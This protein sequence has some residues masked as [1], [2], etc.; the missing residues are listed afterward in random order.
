MTAYYF[1]AEDAQ[2]GFWRCCRLRPTAVIV[3]DTGI[4]YYACPSCA[5]SAKRAGWEVRPSLLKANRGGDRH[6]EVALLHA[7]YRAQQRY[8]QAPTLGEQLLAWYDVRVAWAWAEPFVPADAHVAQWQVRPPDGYL[9]QEIR[10]YGYT[11]ATYQ[12]KVAADEAR[13]CGAE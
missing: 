12:E 8:D 10:P 4:G 3:G 11:E 6:A 7:L 5:G 2:P 1:L 13:A 9:G